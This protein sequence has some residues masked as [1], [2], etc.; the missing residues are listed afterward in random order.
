M[1]QNQSS[2]TAAKVV[3]QLANKIINAPSQ[4]EIRSLFV[5]LTQTLNTTSKAQYFC[6]GQVSAECN[7]NKTISKSFGC[8]Q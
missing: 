3:K 1:A 6:I 2:S 7:S 5:E 4:P 8:I